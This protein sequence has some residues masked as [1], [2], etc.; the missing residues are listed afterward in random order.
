MT[1]PLWTLPLPIIA[2]AAID[3]AI[4]KARTLGADRRRSTTPRVLTGTTEITVGADIPRVR[5]LARTEPK[6]AA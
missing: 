2:I 5:V 6:D 1:I 3:W 4:E